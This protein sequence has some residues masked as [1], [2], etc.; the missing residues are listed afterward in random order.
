MQQL[1]IPP[2]SE[3]ETYIGAIGNA[4]GEVYHIVLLPGDSE[5]ASHADQLAWAQS[6]GGDLP[7]RVEQAM[8][9]AGHKALFK[10]TWYWSNQLD[11][12]GWA[13]TQTFGHCTQDYY[14]PYHAL[15]ARAVR[16]LP[17]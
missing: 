13:W 10:E 12:D 4:Q 1:Q 16:R 7:N 11:D 15:R 14:H 6:I 8:L 9:F 17:I 3:G 2:L 5:P